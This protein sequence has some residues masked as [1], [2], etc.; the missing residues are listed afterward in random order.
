MR[1]L[2]NIHLLTI[3]IS[4][5]SLPETKI[6]LHKLRKCETKW[7]FHLKKLGF[8][9]TKKRDMSMFQKLKGRKSHQNSSNI[10]NPLPMPGYIDVYRVSMLNKTLE[11]LIQKGKTC[12]HIE[13]I[14]RI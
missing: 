12:S 10:C 7:L 5:L 6:L 11:I 2:K 4:I 9:T 1:D 13:Q 14:K 3:K 8:F